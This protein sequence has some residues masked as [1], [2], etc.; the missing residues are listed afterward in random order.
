MQIVVD[1]I[2]I[3]NKFTFARHLHLPLETEIKLCFLVM[4]AGYGIFAQPCLAGLRLALC[5]D[6]R[7]RAIV[8]ILLR[9]IFIIKMQFEH[10]I[11]RLMD[12]LCWL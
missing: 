10:V 8:I 7:V 6:R 4:S 1:F 3:R 9:T 5:L 11:G 12:L 2:E